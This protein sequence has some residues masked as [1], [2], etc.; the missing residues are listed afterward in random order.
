MDS[1]WLVQ[2]DK[3][4]GTSRWGIKT[5]NPKDWS[6]GVNGYQGVAAAINAHDWDVTDN[7]SGPGSKILKQP[8]GD[9]VYRLLSNVSAWANFATTRDNPD[10]GS[11][12]VPWQEWLSLEYIH[13]NLH[14]SY[15]VWSAQVLS[16]TSQCWQA[17]QFRASLA[18][19]RWRKAS[20][21]C[22]TSHLQPSTPSSTFI[23]GKTTSSPATLRP[24]NTVSTSNVDRLAAIWQTLNPDTWFIQGDSPTSKD[25]L[26]PFHKT[27]A[28]YFTSD[29]VRDWTT[30]GYQYDGLQRDSNE[31]DDAYMKRIKKSI[32]KL[33]SSNT[34]RVLLADRASLFRQVK[35]QDHTYDD[36]VIDVLYDR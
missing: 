4:A 22:K 26:T 21:T 12:A 33:Y 18:V 27:D 32:E 11:T 3:C 29:D 34:G 2:W 10:T 16:F 5:S 13:N 14:V 9:V 7:K 19:A 23:T 24:S 20:D 1:R 6:S 28:K 31:T 8:V 35:V 17:Q 15:P 30:L 25:I 36:Y